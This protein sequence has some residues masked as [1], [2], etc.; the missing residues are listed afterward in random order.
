MKGRTHTIESAASIFKQKGCNVNMDKGT[1]L[2]SKEF[3][4][5]TKMLG[6]QDYLV[7]QGFT[8]LR[9]EK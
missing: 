9:K 3:Q 2:M 1:I 4:L 6:K 5:G 8:F 7:S